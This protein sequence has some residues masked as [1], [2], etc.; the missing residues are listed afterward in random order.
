MKK[1]TA[2][3]LIAVLL[4]LALSAC[5]LLLNYKSIEIV[6]NIQTVF[7]KDEQLDLS[8][9]TLRATDK[10]GKVTDIPG[11]HSA[12]KVTG[13]DTATPGQKTMRFSIGGAYIDIPY[14]VYT[15]LTKVNS[16]AELEA[17]LA[18][19]YQNIKLT[20]NISNV[21]I[22]LQRDVTIVGGGAKL[23]GAI[24]NAGNYKLTLA[25]IN[26]V[27]GFTVNGKEATL[28]NC[29]IS[30]EGA[31][32]KIV[33]INYSTKKLV[34]NYCS[35]KTAPENCFEYV[36]KKTENNYDSEAVIKNTKVRCNFWY[37][38]NVPK[39]F[40][41]DSCEINSTLT[42]ESPFKDSYGAS[43]VNPNK[44]PVGIHFN[45]N[46]GDKTI[47]INASVTNTKISNVQ[48]VI[49]V[50]GLD[51]YN[52]KDGLWNFKWDNNDVSVNCNN[53]VNFSTKS[54]GS[55]AALEEAMGSGI[56]ARM[57]AAQNTAIK[58]AE[59]KTITLIKLG[60]GNDKTVLYANALYVEKDG[61]TP[62]EFLGWDK[63][64][65]MVLRNGNSYYQLAV[66]YSADGLDTRTI[67]PYT[68][69]TSIFA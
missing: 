22:E 29:T 47:G 60:E 36:I 48:N 51:L 32:T 52:G 21:D 14:T 2:L 30:L 57:V 20:G 19:G 10:N 43:F 28:E 68:G 45:A 39:T 54:Y 7:E 33:G 3:V 31:S 26:L 41:I 63:D 67:T 16:A 8:K 58:A 34:I 25:D 6:G 35:F 44:N 11:T 1:K 64:S 24:I 13:F 50:Y 40:T 23:Y 15:D 42:T 37:G 55:L 27:N 65:K 53:I 66:A 18:N 12:L 59:G 5:T 46:G 61:S 62:Y 38:L 69:D 56:K 9:I 4:V 17:A 49:R